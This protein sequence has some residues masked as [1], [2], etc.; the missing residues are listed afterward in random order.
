MKKSSES[1]SSLLEFNQRTLN[2]TILLLKTLDI[3]TILSEYIC[4]IESSTLYLAYFMLF[5][6]LEKLHQN[7]SF[8]FYYCKKM[9]KNL[10]FE[11][12]QTKQKI[13]Y[14]FLKQS[15]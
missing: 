3:N 15:K 13:Q 12:F 8:L 4:S 7:T 6:A 10:N 2:L 9:V 1:H 11:H 5:S 14:K